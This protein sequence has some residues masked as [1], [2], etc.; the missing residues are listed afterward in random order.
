MSPLQGALPNL[1][2]ATPL[3]PQPSPYGASMFPQVS[4][5]GMNMQPG[6]RALH[7]P[8]HVCTSD[9]RIFHFPAPILSDLLVC[10]PAFI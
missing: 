1:Q 5:Y 10:W 7:S 2:A 4:R 6:N 8:F 9:I 3:Q